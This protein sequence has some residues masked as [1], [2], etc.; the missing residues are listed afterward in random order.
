MYSVD[1]DGS[2]D[3]IFSLSRELGLPLNLPM[4]SDKFDW[5]L[6]VEGTTDVVFYKK[7]TSS[8]K[9]FKNNSFKSEF[10]TDEEETLKDIS[11]KR[12]NDSR[13]KILRLIEAKVKDDRTKHY[14]GIMDSDYW[15][16]Q[17]DVSI[18]KNIMFTDANSLETMMYKWAG[19]D[20][21]SRKIVRSFYGN[22]SDKE[23]DAILK[24]ALSFSLFV[25]TLRSQS[26]GLSY[27]KIEDYSKYLEYF[28]ND[29]SF[30]FNKES[31]LDDLINISNLTDNQK[32]WI[33]EMNK[34]CEELFNQ[35]DNLYT[36]Q[37]HDLM[38]F[39]KS[40]VLVYIKARGKVRFST[41]DKPSYVAINNFDTNWF[42]DSPIYKWIQDIENQKKNEENE[43][44]SL[45]NS[46]YRDYIVS[47]SK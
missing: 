41:K 25:G 27:K 11:K 42:I 24:Y 35:K 3:P 4:I 22:L 29:C 47:V 18:K 9:E 44:K 19:F 39:I 17:Y 10:E 31:Y 34:S 21:F 45:T 23:S 5:I 37:G 12:K 46:K 20:N 7:F 8:F 14:Y 1:R 36:I 28:S 38:N 15:R 30:S 40:L 26:L 32:Y 33:E 43:E 6:L 2:N 16:P 13:K